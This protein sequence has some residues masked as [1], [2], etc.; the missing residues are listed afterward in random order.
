MMELG[1]IIYISLKKA[2]R[3]EK[4]LRREKIIGGEVHGEKTCDRSRKRGPWG[5]VRKGFR[6]EVVREGKET[7]REVL[8]DLMIHS[9]NQDRL[10]KAKKI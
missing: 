2:Y 10:K 3:G 9:Q 5:I 1:D 7:K 6:E 4:R 8:K